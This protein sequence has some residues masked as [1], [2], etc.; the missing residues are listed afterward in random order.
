[1]ENVFSKIT[2]IDWFVDNTLKASPIPF[3]DLNHVILFSTHFHSHCHTFDNET[4][5][6]EIETIDNKLNIRQ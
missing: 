3:W 4:D 5:F 2:T 1:M 6:M